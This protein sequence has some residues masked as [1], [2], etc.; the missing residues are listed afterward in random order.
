MSIYVN[1]WEV[2]DRR[3]DKLQIAQINIQDKILF[4]LMKLCWRQS[5]AVWVFKNET[6]DWHEKLEHLEP[7]DCAVPLPQYCFV[8]SRANSPPRSRHELIYGK[9]RLSNHGIH[10]CMMFETNTKSAGGAFQNILHRQKASRD[11]QT[12]RKLFAKRGWKFYAWKLF[13]CIN[14]SEKSRTIEAV[15]ARRLSWKITMKKPWIEHKKLI[16]TWDNK[17]KLFFRESFG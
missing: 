2:F 15:L 3:E 14:A 8:L 9:Y 17:P 4:V 6:A 16:K 5:N 13:V 10:I 7:F 1:D 11:L 12:M